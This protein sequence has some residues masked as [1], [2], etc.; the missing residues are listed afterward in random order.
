MSQSDREDVFARVEQEN[1][2]GPPF[3]VHDVAAALLQQPSSQR[4][5]NAQVHT[6]RYINKYLSQKVLQKRRKKKKKG[7]AII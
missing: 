3:A 4:P 7:H 2:P 1:Q 5:Q 6:L